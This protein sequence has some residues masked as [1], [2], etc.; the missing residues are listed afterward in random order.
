M[1]YRGAAAALVVFDLTTPSSF[2]TLKNWVKELRTLG[3]ENIVIAICANKADLEDRRV[4]W[5]QLRLLRRQRLFRCSD[6]HPGAMHAAVASGHPL[7]HFSLPLH[8]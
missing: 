1:Y 2:A 8:L 4:R 5:G 3:P 7:D 6:P